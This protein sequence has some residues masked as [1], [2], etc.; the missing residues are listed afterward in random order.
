MFGRHKFAT[1]VGALGAALV[2]AHVVL[3]PAVMPV[4]GAAVGLLLVAAAGVAIVAVERLS[5]NRDNRRSE[6]GP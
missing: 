1:A 6:R 2:L 4:A 3:G 5:S